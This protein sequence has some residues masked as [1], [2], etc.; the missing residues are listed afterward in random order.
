VLIINDAR[1]LYLLLAIDNC[2]QLDDDIIVLKERHP[3]YQKLL[4]LIRRIYPKDKNLI[5]KGYDEYEE[6]M[7]STYASTIASERSKNKSVMFGISKS[8]YKLASTQARILTYDF[9][10]HPSIPVL[11]RLWNLADKE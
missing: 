11:K 2:K 1:L 5:R 4:P 7:L 6:E 10:R 3:N 9:F 8:K